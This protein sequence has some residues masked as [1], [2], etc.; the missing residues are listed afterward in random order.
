[1]LPWSIEGRFDAGGN[2]VNDFRSLT[3]C[4]VGQKAIA[5]DDAVAGLADGSKKAQT[6][7]IV[8]T[9]RVVG[10][11]QVNGVVEIEEQPADTTSQA[12]QQPVRNQA[13]LN[14]NR[15]KMGK[16]GAETEAAPQGPRI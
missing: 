5:G 10:V 6:L 3:P 13:A 16:I 11:A 9:A 12:L 2:D 4:F 1:M 8:Q 7:R 14:D 15:A